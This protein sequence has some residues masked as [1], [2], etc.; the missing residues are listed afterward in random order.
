MSS[1]QPYVEFPFEKHIWEEYAHLVT[2]SFNLKSP[3]FPYIEE[4]LTL[5][6]EAVN[7]KVRQDKIN[8]AIEQGL[9]ERHGYAVHVFSMKAAEGRIAE[10]DFKE[11]EKDEVAQIVLSYIRTRYISFSDKNFKIM[12]SPIGGSVW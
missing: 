4:L 6:H 8:E 9:H 3:A 5:S 2:N 11:M 10:F 1:L 12:N 7:L